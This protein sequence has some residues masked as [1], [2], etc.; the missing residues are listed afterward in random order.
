MNAYCPNFSNKQIKEEFQELV[1]VFGT[2]S[3]AY[4]LWDM[5]NGFSLDKSP[6]GEESKLFSGLL[7]KSKTREEALKKTA[8]CLMSIRRP[9]VAPTIQQKTISLSQDILS[10]VGE[11][12]QKVSIP[13][14]GYTFSMSEKDGICFITINF[15][16][17]NQL[18]E[19]INKKLSPAL[20]EIG[21]SIAKN[22][23]GKRKFLF[24]NNSVKIQL[25][26]TDNT[27]KQNNETQEQEESGI[28]SLAFYRYDKAL[29]EAEQRNFDMVD[30][31]FVI[32][33]KKYQKPEINQTSIN[34]S[35]DLLSSEHDGTVEPTKTS[36]E[37]E[38]ELESRRQLFVQEKLA[39]FEEK[40]IEETG[41][42]GTT[43]RYVKPEGEDLVR[44][45]MKVRDDARKQFD[46]EEIN[47]IKNNDSLSEAEKQIYFNVLYKDIQIVSDISRIHEVVE[48][49]I[50]QTVFEEIKAG[51]K[52]R[53]RSHYSR[54][55]KET[56][57]IQDLKEQIA[58]MEQVDVSDIDQ[59]IESVKEFLENAEQEIL[60]TRRFIDEDLLGKDISTW[61]PQ[62]I[63][64]IRYDLLGYY[65]GLLNAIY[66]MFKE[67][68]KIAE[69]NR[70]RALE[71][72]L[73][74]RDLEDLVTKLSSIVDR[75]KVDYQ[76]RVVIPYAEK[77]LTDFVND[78]DAVKD[79]PAF[80]A[81]MKKWLAQDTA[82]GDLQ[83]G[84][85]VIGMASRSRSPIIRIMEKMISDVEF[86]KNREV[87]KVG[88]ELIRLY[89]K[90][91]PTG[92]QMDF[93]NFQKMFME[94]DG[95]DGTS[96]RTTGY[97][98]RDRNYG[99][100]YKEKDEYEAKL[101]EEFKEEGLKWTINEY[102]N[103]IELVFPEEDHTA[104]DSLY[105]RY[106]DKLDKWLDEHCE[107]RYKLAYYRAKRRFLSPKALQAQQMIQHQ[108]DILS[109]KAMTE[110][111]FVDTNKLK[112]YERQRLADLR[113]QKRELACPYIF[114]E[115]TDGTITLEEKVG[116]DAEIARQISAWNAFIAKH[117]KY[118]AREDK[119]NEALS[120][121][122]PG[123]E[124]YKRF[125]GANR[126]Q[127]INPKLW[128][129]ALGANR[130]EQTKE[131]QELQERYRAIV[132]HTKRHQGYT[133]PNLDLL[134]LGIDTD[135]SVWEELQ[136]IEQRMAEIRISNG[137]KS[138]YEE[139]FGSFLVKSTKNEKNFL[140]WLQERWQYEISADPSKEE[141]FRKLF[142][143]VDRKGRQRF[144]KIFGMHNPLSFTF[145]YNGTTENT[146]VYQYSSQFS[147]L[148]ESSDFVNPNY[149]KEIKSSMQ[150]KIREKGTERKAGTIDYT[151]DR[152]N[153]V[154]ANEGYRQ[155]YD[156]LLEIMDKANSMIPQ[157]AI[158]R[159]YLMP[160]ITGRGMSILGRSRG[161]V[162]LL[163]ALN[164][165]LLDW[166][167]LKVTREGIGFDSKI[168]EQDQ[169]VSTN[170][171]LPRRPDG[172]IVNNIPIRF[173]K[174]LE[175]PSIISTD[176]IGAVLIY[177][178][179]ALNYKMKSE[180]LPA[181]ELMLEA[182][183]PSSKERSGKKSLRKQYE[184]AKN[185]L[186]FRY[187][188]KESK[189][190]DDETKAQS[191]LGKSTM[192]ITKKF[193][194]LASLSMLALNFTTIEVG[195][196][197]AL[198]GSIADSIG[199][200]YFTP[201]DLATG[202]WETLKSLPQ[203]LGNLGKPVV[204]N[205]MVAAMQYNQ[206]S[207]SNSEIFGRTDQSKWSR[208]L[209]QIRMGG[210]TM[211]DYMIN[212]MILGATY[213][214]YRLVEMPYGAGKRFMS[215][216]DAIDVFTKA[217][218][219]E[220]E[221]ISIWESS[222]ETLKQ[223]YYVEDGL[224]KVKEKYAPYINKKLE[225]QVAGRLR[226]RTAVYNGVI[227]ATEKA[228]IQQNVFGSYLT[229]MRNFYVNTY[230]ERASAGYDYAT[231]EELKSSKLGMFTADSAG[232]VNFETGEFG[233]GVW[234]SFLKGLYKYVYNVKALVNKK[235]VRQLTRD[236]KQAVRRILAELV[237]I[238]G[239]I[240]AML[241]S[242]AFARSNDDDDKD[243]VW[244]V[245]VFDPENEDRSW[246]EVDW[247]RSGSSALNWVRWKMALLAT[248]T[249]T[250]RTT[251]YWPG[252][253]TELLT[254]PSTAKSYLDDLG[255]SLELFMDLFE[256]NG[257]DR[258]EVV[259]SG[260]YKGMTRGTR[261]IMKITGATG[262]DN[263]IRNWHTS[264]LKS[265]LNWYSGVS[266]NNFL[267][268]NKTTWEKQNG[269]STQKSNGLA[270]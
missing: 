188:G 191:K 226:D 108:I 12:K 134:G 16:N 80:I 15:K 216:S 175:D 150:P 38:A 161:A 130:I 66:G 247:N 26:K 158:E 242:I 119:F 166:T 141:V 198:L 53:L 79:K 240:W 97:F 167:G 117:V 199:G 148:D 35:K 25:E 252:T 212:T 93:R 190:G 49:P 30:E 59:L 62:Q 145:D 210:Y 232:I 76:D 142:T 115:L 92:S 149:K 31:D 136:R 127:I 223:A 155:L 249:F 222:K 21:I 159:N 23:D 58:K 263:V 40:G 102:T 65:E 203:I 186:D 206:L 50:E 265:T 177:F 81:N 11:I 100:F 27:I 78:S 189:L 61:D 5:N 244:T 91:R 146:L 187:Y 41:E 183:N 55:V 251:F 32:I 253:V 39:E 169:D 22:Q 267:I 229:L 105:N 153:E 152:F 124:E 180:N 126:I 269:G 83:I 227:P 42:G 194:S 63:N 129:V 154:M 178:D 163:A 69:L 257:H 234:Y 235:D 211:G 37:I 248:R 238:G 164:Y 225:N 170:W 2:T 217:G 132:N 256:I 123:S 3:K 239:C 70:V 85:L 172:S 1:D 112:P 205:W 74:N 202:Y 86:E 193:R 221:A 106:Y 43:I 14:Q 236:Q 125:V 98:V 90:V 88:N 77:V 113:N 94:L 17:W 171:D 174:R 139:Y 103:Q 215:K 266:P 71:N 138:E 18:K 195:Y 162:D 220:D 197:D 7:S 29:Y 157:G 4:F 99:R 52:T 121:Y 101:R 140:D 36:S 250:E 270:Y 6:S 254:S 182:L 262:I 268:P 48:K 165:A 196:L 260:G 107:R 19:I 45:R 9:Y 111:G 156:K 44:A 261:D 33:R 60:R 228:A 75:L 179:M 84:E 181:L 13:L 224:L 47:K 114:H 34:P 160:Q 120:K 122:E 241:W 87:L 219:T 89:N 264:G 184:K 72:P 259:R 213:N 24:L 237:I 173:I 192:Q 46:I 243:P 201:T 258:N 128:E 73:E 10:S 131:Y 118:K 245:N 133:Q 214:H 208:M 51:T 143:F 137:E 204:N 8:K 54:N 207:K 95:E 218:K 176:V 57:I 200:K 28:S 209:S 67:N 68:S 185:V 151:N 109:Q 116:E 231:K 255:Y 20:S 82:Y 246:L 147:E 230:W 96:G 233:N 104:E 168:M 110:D 56:K 144:L 64:Y 135:R